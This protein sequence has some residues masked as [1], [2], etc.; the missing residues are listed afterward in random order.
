[1]PLKD[2]EKWLKDQSQTQESYRPLVLQLH[3]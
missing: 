3:Y 2:I 1:M